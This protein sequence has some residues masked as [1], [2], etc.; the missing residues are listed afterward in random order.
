MAA[1]LQTTFLDSFPWMKNVVTKVPS[2]TLW[3]NE[4]TVM[5]E[6]AL[7][8]TCVLATNFKNIDFLLT[9][10][11]DKSLPMCFVKINWKGS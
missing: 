5:S 1:I 8:F 10:A 9:T 3:P 11:G 6:A 4:R 2:A 7:K